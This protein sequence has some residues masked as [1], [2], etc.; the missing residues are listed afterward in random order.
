M[1]K[2]LA[3]ITLMA[4][5][6]RLGT[7]ALAAENPDSLSVLTEPAKLIAGI[8]RSHH[9][10]ETDRG[11]ALASKALIDL[12]PLLNNRP[13]SEIADPHLKTRKV[14]QIA[15]TLHTLLGM[16]EQRRALQLLQAESAR[17][18]KKLAEY[19]KAQGK[20]DNAAID[21]R[22]AVERAAANLSANAVK[23]LRMAIKLD[24]K[25]PS[26]HYEL[27]KIYAA[28]LPGGTAA[29]EEEYYLAALC[30]LDEGDSKAA[31]STMG[32]VAVLNPRSKFLAQFEQKRKAGA[33]GE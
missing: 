26:P 28:G 5:L 17:R 2:A 4:A 16:L 1:N 25:N 6:I 23:E 31:Q 20:I 8:Y 24:P 27:A 10:W 22:I 14:R 29:A 15:S 32:L 12:D 11:I 21:Q 18:D 3:T 33:R 19:D 13:D 30:A 9:D 7:S